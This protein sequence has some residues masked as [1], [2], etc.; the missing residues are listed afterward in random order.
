MGRGGPTVGGMLALVRRYA[1]DAAAPALLFAASLAQPFV[2]AEEAYGDL[3]ATGV[4]LAALTCLAL[5]VRRRWPVPV[6]AATVAGALGYVAVAGKLSPFWIA[7]PVAAY[8]VGAHAGRKAALVAVPAAALL[9][10]AGAAAL[11]GDWP[12][13]H[14]TGLLAWTALGGAIGYAV[15]AWRENVS[16]VKDRALRAERT[17]EEEARRRVAE[18]RLRVARDLHDVVAH[19]IAVINVQAG[20]ASHM[21]REQP[22]SAQRALAHIRQA[23][24]TVL[25]ELGV[26]LGVLRQ[27][28]DPAAPT[29]PAPSLSRLD[30]LIDSFTATGLTV[31]RS[32]SGKP[33]PLPAAVDLAA[34]R[35]VQESLTNVHRHGKGA[36]ARVSIA[37]NPAEL[38]IEV[39][40]VRNGT[41]AS[42]PA[43]ADE[44]RTGLGILGMRERVAS[45]GGQLSAGPEPDGGFRVRAVLRLSRETDDDPDRAR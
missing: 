6:L 33:R 11:D 28:G 19:H 2:L 20:V 31:Q 27:P 37:Y 34:Y 44:G 5:A 26:L 24:R 42:P 13:P 36:G 10:T 45:V 25:D 39:H 14:Y 41:P 16:A 4:T 7:V 12:T 15:R 17:R 32:L 29:E 30:S 1:A 18:E 23:S 9:L 21:L 43:T 3:S 40:N 35:V 22:E 8:T 38:S